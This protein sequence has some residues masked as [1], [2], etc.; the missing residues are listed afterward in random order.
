MNQIYSQCNTY[1]GGQKKVAFKYLTE[2]V[3]LLSLLSTIYV[4][5]VLLYDFLA[6]SS[7]LTVQI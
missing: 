3:N 1:E 2:K 6:R 5:D 7:V 4:A